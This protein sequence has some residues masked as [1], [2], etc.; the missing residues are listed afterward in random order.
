M[1]NTL[2]DEI[3]ELFEEYE[4]KKGKHPKRFNWDDFNSMEEYKDYLK[5]ELNE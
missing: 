1:E 5:K 3:K 4:Q 2:N